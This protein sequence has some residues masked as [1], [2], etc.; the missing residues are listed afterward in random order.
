M[1]PIPLKL[2]PSFILMDVQGNS[3]TNYVY[4]LEGDEVKVKKKEFVKKI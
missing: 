3:I 4:Q 1:R 2:L